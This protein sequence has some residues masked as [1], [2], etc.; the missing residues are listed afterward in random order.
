[1][2]CEEARHHDAGGRDQ[3][4]VQDEPGLAD[5]V[6]A[7][8]EDHRADCLSREEAERMHREGGGARAGREFSHFRLHA[9][10]Q[11]HEACARENEAKRHH[12]PW[13]QHRHTS[14][15]DTC[16]HAAS[17]HHLAAAEMAEQDR[18]SER[19]EQAT[20]AK[21]GQHETR[22]AR[23]AQM[24]PLQNV[25]DIGR[26]AIDRDAFQKHRAEAE[27]GFRIGKDA[28]IARHRI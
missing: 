2:S 11:H 8:A 3:E 12:R 19:V 23:R 22:F 7:K 10:M 16:Q 27:I 15:A 1:M 25:A 26:R 28:A 17:R 20:N 18:Q 5:S 13:G 6:D 14:K 9:V 4:Q 24:V 21:A